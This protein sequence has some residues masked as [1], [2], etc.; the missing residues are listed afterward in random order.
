MAA[1]VHFL[2]EFIKIAVLSTC[3]AGLIMLIGRLTFSRGHF[4]FDKL[5][6]YIYAVLF[7]FLFT[8]YGN[9]GLGDE[10]NLPIGHW[11]TVQAGDGYP[12]FEPSGKG[13]IRL[14]SFLVDQETLCAKTGKGYMAY[15][16]TTD[17]LTT[18]PDQ[19][20]YNA[21]AAK[22][23]LSTIDKFKTFAVQYSAYW[24]GWRFWT[25]P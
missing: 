2:F 3:Y 11:E 16:L 4:K 5:F 25:L 23:N 21:F 15:N 17:K 14:E 18:F 9:H 7:I 13:Q 22:N 19:L 24:D 6:C 12:Y 1:S 8:Y 10:S 20:S